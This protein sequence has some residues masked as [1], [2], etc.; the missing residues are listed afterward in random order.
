[1]QRWTVTTPWWAVVLAWGVLFGLLEVWS[2]QYVYHV[3]WTTALSGGGV[4]VLVF[5]LS[6]GWG[7]HRRSRGFR[8]ALAE[9]APAQ[10]PEALRAARGGAVPEA[11][12]VRAAAARVAYRRLTVFR[13]RVPF[14]FLLLAF[15]SAEAAIGLDGRGWLLAAVYLGLAA[16]GVSVSRQLRRRIALLQRDPAALAHG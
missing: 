5:C 16:L 4:A 6:V 11:P 7:E 10:T 3:G 15:T 13:R 2:G 8:D 14:V 12:E 9:L 1:M